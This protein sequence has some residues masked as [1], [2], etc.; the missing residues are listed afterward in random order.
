MQEQS[1]NN[2]W[3]R[4]HKS[5]KSKGYPL[6]VMFE[7]TYQCNFNCRHC[8][9][10]QSY[11]NKEGILTTKEVF[12]ILDELADIGCFYLGFTG[13]EPF[14]RKDFIEVL[15]HAKRKGFEIIIYT[16]GSL[17]DEEMAGIL[18]DIR[19]N[20][21]DITIPA[22][23]KDAFERITKSPGSH[24]KV[25]NAIDLLHKREVAL[26]FKSC[27]LKDNEDEI[28]DIED[29]AHSLKALHRLDNKL[30]PRLDGS[31][32][33]YKYRGERREYRVQSRL[34]E[35][36][37][38][39][40]PNPEPRTTNHE[41]RTTDPDNLF[42][43]GVGERQAAITPFGELKMC[44]MIDEPRYDILNKETRTKIPNLKKA[45][46]ELK[47]FAGTI[48]P[49][50]NYKCEGCERQVYC[51]WCPAKAWLYNKT[52]TSCVPESRKWAGC[53]GGK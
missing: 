23:S 39:E 45:W 4:L 46:K 9:V 8:Y 7:L 6:R 1:Y 47:E 53:V 21:V 42:K 48:K 3:Q 34:L 2:F 32:E 19:P 38:C 37:G 16:N 33:P 52:F 22:M 5:A 43:C 27:L 11:R 44:L 10:P 24:K 17:I 12:L 14:V 35:K 51:K 49:D 50:E 20:K 40:T 13:G 28:K 29:F 30:M 18:A 31:E 26:G 36:S 15:R 41:P 25:F